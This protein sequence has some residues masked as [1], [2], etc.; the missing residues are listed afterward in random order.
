MSLSCQNSNRAP[1]DA[2][3]KRCRL[4][5]TEE[6]TTTSNSL[7]TSFHRRHHSLQFLARQPS[8]LRYQYHT[9]AHHTRVGVIGQQQR[10]ASHKRQISMPPAKFE[11]TFP[12]RPRPQTNALDRASTELAYHFYS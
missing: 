10:N 1:P 2:S 11:P 3:W 5:L 4:S 7:P 12:L 8:S 9:Q 6:T